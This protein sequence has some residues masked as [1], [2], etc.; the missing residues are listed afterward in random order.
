MAGEE[1]HE[2]LGQRLAPDW[3][4]FAA[5]PG[6]RRRCSASAI[7]D[8]VRDEGACGSLVPHAMGEPA[9]GKGY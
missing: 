1:R 9:K 5:I 7:S 2:H 3:Q 8:R 6:R 4:A